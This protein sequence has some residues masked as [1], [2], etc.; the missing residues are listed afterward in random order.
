[1]L[2]T[3]TVYKLLWMIM[4]R[5]FP[6][7]LHCRGASYSICINLNF[8]R[9]GL[10]LLMLMHLVMADVMNA[11]GMWIGHISLVLLLVVISP[12]ITAMLHVTVNFLSK[13]CQEFVFIEGIFEIIHIWKVF[14]ATLSLLFYPFILIKI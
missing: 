14:E 3:L 4:I 1:M 7:S 12:H 2:H 9:M 13:I 11:C 8:S 6:I 5:R 10:S